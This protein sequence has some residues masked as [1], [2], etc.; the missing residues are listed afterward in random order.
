MV[1]YSPFSSLLLYLVYQ[2]FY[3][4]PFTRVTFFGEKFCLSGGTRC[5][6]GVRCLFEVSVLTGKRKKKNVLFILASS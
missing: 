1:N 6:V 2:T 3:V 5:W 4:V